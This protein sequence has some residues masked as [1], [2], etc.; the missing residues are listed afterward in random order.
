MAKSYGVLCKKCGEHIHLADIEPEAQNE[1]TFYTP[2]LTPV[3][4]AHCGHTDNYSSKDN[5][6]K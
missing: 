4:C 3:V 2:P 6:Y 5:H 1:I